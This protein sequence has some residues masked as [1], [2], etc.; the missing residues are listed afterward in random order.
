M[1]KKQNQPKTRRYTRTRNAIGYER[2][3]SGDFACAHWMRAERW[4]YGVSF[5][6]SGDVPLNS[7]QCRELAAWLI[8]AAERMEA[9][10]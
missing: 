2:R 3:E 1:A 4:F 9:T 10:K 6:R 5:D 7:K 8:E